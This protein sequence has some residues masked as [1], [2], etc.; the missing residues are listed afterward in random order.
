MVRRDDHLLTAWLRVPLPAPPQSLRRGPFARRAFSS[1][2]RSPWL[3]SRLGLALGICFGVCFLTG[4]LSHAIQHPP[5][6]FWWPARPVSLYRVTQGLHVAT[7]LA[8]IPL[9]GAKV[10]SVYPRLFTWP[11]ARDPGHA[12]ERASVAVLSAAALF[13]LVSGLLNIAHWYTLMPWGFL[14]AHFWTAW[15][16]VGA[17]LLHVA[18]KL[19]VIRDGLRRQRFTVDSDERGGLTRRGVLVAAGSAV[20]AVTVATI[21]QTV[22]PLAPVSV[23]ALRVAHVGPQGLPVNMTASGAGVTDSAR[24]PGYRLVLTGP[25]GHREFTLADLADLPQHTANL[26]I[27]CVECLSARGK[28]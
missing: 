17:I 22:R 9:F 10:W 19:P 11:P 6:W 18:V 24:D 15:L 5:G 12:I 21:G 2:A 23:L 28:L 20:A 7:G 26:P 25:G 14:P 1:R 13:Q 3:T 27:T 16:A 8:A 4:L